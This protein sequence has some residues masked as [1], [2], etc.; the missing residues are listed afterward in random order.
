MNPTFWH[1]KRV[2][3]TGHTGFKGSW[4]SLWLQSLGADVIAYSLPPPT[5]PNMF[6]VA[7]VAD[8]I[9][10]ILGDVRDAERLG[11]SWQKLSR[12]LCFTWLLNLW[13]A[14]HIKPR[15]RHMPPM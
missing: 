15:S 11:E 3:I 7:S 12:R 5:D 8:G 1:G 9:A 14:N 4:L 6:T 10:S 2:L 13:S